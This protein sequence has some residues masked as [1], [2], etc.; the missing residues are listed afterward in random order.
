MA[1]IF[2]VSPLRN[3]LA[4]LHCIAGL[5]V[6][7]PDMNIVFQVRR[8]SYGPLEL[9]LRPAL[10]GRKLKPRSFLIPDSLIAIPIR[11]AGEQRSMNFLLQASDARFHARADQS[12]APSVTRFR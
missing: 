9:C 6:E 11:A 2:M 12:R 5:P 7:H 8:Q 1:S 3:S 10:C 4:H